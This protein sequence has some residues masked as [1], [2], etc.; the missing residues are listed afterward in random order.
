MPWAMSMPC[1]ATRK[2]AIAAYRAA[3]AC[4]AELRDAYYGLGMALARGDSLTEAIAQF[5]EVVR[6]D[7]THARSHYALGQAYEQQG[8]AAAARRAYG[9]FIRHWR[10][11]EKMLAAAQS[12]IAHLQTPQ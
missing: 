6:R 7:S 10:G 2:K 12:R 11:D 4:D 9:A 1:K 5:E 3:L 8:T